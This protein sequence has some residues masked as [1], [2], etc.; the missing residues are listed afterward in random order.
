MKNSL[1]ILSYQKKVNV[2]S[3]L[4]EL[5]IY[6]EVNFNNYNNI[7]TDFN[8]NAIYKYIIDNEK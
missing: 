5:L 6:N 7:Q 3:V 8:N 1:V 4:V 2:N